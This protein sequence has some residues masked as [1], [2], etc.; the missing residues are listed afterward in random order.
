MWTWIALGAVFLFVYAV[1]G[2]IVGQTAYKVSYKKC[3][4]TTHYECE[5]GAWYFFGAIWPLTGLGFGL[6]YL[7]C[8]VL[9]GPIKIGD[10]V[11]NSAANWKVFNG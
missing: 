9:S 2:S 1:I 10:W 3:T 5:H 11:S 4:R 8:L 6:V 7:V